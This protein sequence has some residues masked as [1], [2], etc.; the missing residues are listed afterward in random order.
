[1]SS[2]EERF[3]FLVEWFDQAAALIR[4]YNLTYFTV[5]N[6]IEMVAFR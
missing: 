4:K 1:M 6:T 3:V 5:D 2:S